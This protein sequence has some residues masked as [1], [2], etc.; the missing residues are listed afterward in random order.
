MDNKSSKAPNSWYFKAVPFWVWL[1][2]N[3]FLRGNF[4]SLRKRTLSKLTN[5]KM[6]SI[7]YTHKPVFILEITNGPVINLHQLNGR[8]NTNHNEE[9]SWQVKSNFHIHQSSSLSLMIFLDKILSKQ[10]HSSFF[11]SMINALEWKKKKKAVTFIPY[12]KSKVNKYKLI[13]Y[14]YIVWTSTIYPTPTVTFLIIFN[15]T[16]HHWLPFA[17][18][19]E[20]FNFNFFPA[21][22]DFLYF[23]LSRLASASICNCCYIWWHIN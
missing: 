18:R 4:L 12:G 16:Y 23:S 2:A 8:N 14:T 1:Q 11:N 15:F 10:N 7:L 17:K 20:E 9:F 6:G 19:L 22:Q 3:L 5:S 13:I 21:T